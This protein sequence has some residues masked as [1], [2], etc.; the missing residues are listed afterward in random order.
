M[1]V[2]SLF[3]YKWISKF[4]FSLT[5][6]KSVSIVSLSLQLKTIVNKRRKKPLTIFNMNITITLRLSNTPGTFCIHEG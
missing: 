5:H 3:L 4:C 1:V 6:F 2:K